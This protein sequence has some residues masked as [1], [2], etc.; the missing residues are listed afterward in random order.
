M[1]HNLSVAMK[2]MI[3]CTYWSS[4]GSPHHHDHYEMDEE[5][6][7]YSAFQ[8]M[9]DEGLDESNQEAVDYAAEV[10]QAESEVYWARQKA[11]GTG[12]KGF[13]SGTRDFKVQGSLTL[14]EKKARIQALKSK[15]Q[16]RKCGQ[17]G[18][19]GD[20]P[21]CPRNSKK[22]GKKGGSPGSTASTSGGKSS[23]KS[24]SPEKSRNVYFTINEYEADRG[25]V[26]G[27]AYMVQ[28][29]YNAV[30]PPECLQDGV[31][32]SGAAAADSS[33]SQHPIPIHERSAEDVMD[34]L[35][36][37]AERRTDKRKKNMLKEEASETFEQHLMSMKK[38]EEMRRMEH[39]DRFMAVVN[40][41]DDPE[42]RDAYNAMRTRRGFNV[43]LR[44]QDLDSQ[45]SRQSRA[46]RT[47]REKVVKEPA[48]MRM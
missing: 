11:F 42:W 33:S 13:W 23:G 5:D 17:Y 28:K 39:L 20:D 45:G 27:S 41:P 32:A 44:R 6:T 24:K 4:E 35:I 30:P 31:G 8:A 43:G 19:W 3:R 7:M 34:E 22:G 21:S 1:H 2:T 12:H 25:G 10:L 9:V 40:D 29:T 36:A 26:S 38:E 46:L 15:T 47:R 14:E 37:E 18:H 48:I 16:R